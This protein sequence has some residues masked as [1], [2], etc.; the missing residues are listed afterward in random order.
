[1][2]LDITTGAGNG[3]KTVNQ[4]LED[5]RATQNSI[6][7]S[8]KAD[9]YK[10]NFGDTLGNFFTGNLDFVRAVEQSKRA[11]AVSAHQALIA[12]NFSAKEAEKQRAWEERMSSTAYSRAVK[13]LQSVGINPYAIGSFNAASTPSGAYGQS[14]A[15][16]GYSGSYHNS[17]SGTAVT[18]SA[19][20]LIGAFAKAIISL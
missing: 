6:A 7:S 2:G 17:R 13:D 8:Y 15:G 10:A 20:A 9:P 19:L 14:F 18:Q 4:Y 1:M 11:E 12:R 5:A 16:S 3:P